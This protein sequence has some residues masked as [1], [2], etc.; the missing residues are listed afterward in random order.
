MENSV[1]S[2]T[3]ARCANHTSLFEYFTMTTIFMVMLFIISPYILDAQVLHWGSISGLV[4]S[5]QGIPVEG[6]INVFHIKAERGASV[7]QSEC[8]IRLSSGE[9]RLPG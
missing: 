6:H 8:S 1:A 2:R 9:F 7:P 3:R 5:E 4:I